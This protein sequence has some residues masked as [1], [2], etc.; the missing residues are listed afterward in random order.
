MPG[1]FLFPVSA[2]SRARPLPQESRKPRP[3][4]FLLERVSPRSKRHGAWHRLRRCSRLKPLPQVQR[5]PQACAN[6][7]WER[8]S[9][10]SKRHGT[11]HRLR[12]CSRLKPLPQVQR[13]PQACANPMWERASPRSKRSG[14]WHRLRRCSRL[15][16]LPQ[17]QREPRPAPIPC[18]SG[19]TREEAGAG[20]QSG[21][22]L[23]KPP[24]QPLSVS[25]VAFCRSLFLRNRALYLQMRSVTR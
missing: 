19:F 8:A 11:W 7:M 1:A 18:G 6:P 20:N 14:A 17:V 24:P 4:R 3:A 12:R 5:E 25:H 15:K 16:P 9:P 23:S 2:P 10:R 21:E 13:E 22:Y